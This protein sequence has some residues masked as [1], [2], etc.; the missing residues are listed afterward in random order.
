[1][2]LPGAA[3]ASNLFSRSRGCALVNVHVPGPLRSYTGGQ[4]V[5]EAHGRTLAELLNFLDGAYPGF[6]FRIIDEQDQIREHI[7]IFVEGEQQLKIRGP[8][9]RGT[10][11][12]IICALSGGA[13]FE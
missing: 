2:V 5:V 12:Q 13:V 3:P 1:M 6:R 8:I 10:E 7:K 11:V 4:R 9:K